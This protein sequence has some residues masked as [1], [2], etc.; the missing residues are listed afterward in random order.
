MLSHFSEGD[1]FPKTAVATARHHV[2][3]LPVDSGLSDRWLSYAAAW[4]IRWPAGRAARCYRTSS[5]CWAALSHVKSCSI[6]RIWM[7]L[8]ESRYSLR[9]AHTH[10]RRNAPSGARWQF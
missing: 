9:P 1:P 7:P 5:Y 4:Q 2:I 8:K 10:R 3:V 6:P